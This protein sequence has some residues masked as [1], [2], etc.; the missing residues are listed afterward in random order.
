MRSAVWE[1]NRKYYDKKGDKQK[2]I[3]ETNKKDAVKILE[4]IFI[5]L[6]YFLFVLLIVCSI[7]KNNFLE[8]EIRNSNIIT[9]LF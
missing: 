8:K 6:F 2:W 3:N 5:L 4:M 7:E 9:R 1:E